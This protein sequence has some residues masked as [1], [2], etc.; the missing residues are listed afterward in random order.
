MYVFFSPAALV[1]IC[2]EMSYFGWLQGKEI[3]CLFLPLYTFSQKFFS[4]L[5]FVVCRTSNFHL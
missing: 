4:H 1:V 2:A 3:R 5:Y